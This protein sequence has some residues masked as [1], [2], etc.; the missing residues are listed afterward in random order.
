MNSGQTDLPIL[1]DGNA[2]VARQGER[3]ISRPRFLAE[4]EQLAE[5][6]PDRPYVVNFCTDRYRFTVAWAAAMLRRQITLLPP[7]RLAH[8]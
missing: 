7:G 3:I 2:P 6:L 5:R 1:R 8:V 4:I